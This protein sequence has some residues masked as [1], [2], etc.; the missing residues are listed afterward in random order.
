MIERADILKINFKFL[1]IVFY[2][3]DVLVMVW[4]TRQR[5]DG[6]EAEV[7]QGSA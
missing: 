1:S 5:E 7:G 3:A 2:N 4:C 6:G